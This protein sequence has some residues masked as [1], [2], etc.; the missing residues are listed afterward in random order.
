MRF[1]IRVALPLILDAIRV[2]N[3]HIWVDIIIGEL[4]QAFLFFG[5]LATAMEREDE[6]VSIGRCVHSRQVEKIGPLDA[7]AGNGQS[8]R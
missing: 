8:V 7:G 1:R 6:A 4:R 2:Y 3:Q 5:V